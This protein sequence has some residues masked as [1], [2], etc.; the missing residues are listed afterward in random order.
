M[1][2][3]PEA[4]E[5]PQEQAQTLTMLRAADAVSVETAVRMAQ[6]DLDDEKLAEEVERIRE[7]SGRVVSE[8]AF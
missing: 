4:R 2:A 5:T 7:D 3:W 1:L 6:P 8:P